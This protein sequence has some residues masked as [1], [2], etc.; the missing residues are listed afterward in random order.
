[1]VREPQRRLA[2]RRRALGQRVDAAGAV[3]HRVLR[4]HVE[5]GEAHPDPEHTSATR[6]LRGGAASIPLVAGGRRQGHSFDAD[7]LPHKQALHFQAQRL[8][9]VA[10]ADNDQLRPGFDQDA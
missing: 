4:V 5:M 6:R 3:E 7:A 1:V 2:K 10:D 8:V 9:G